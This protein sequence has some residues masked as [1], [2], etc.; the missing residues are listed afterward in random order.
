MAGGF[1]NDEILMI[2]IN[3]LLSHA[4][5]KDPTLKYRRKPSESL[6]STLNPIKIK[7]ED[8]LSALLAATGI[9][10]QQDAKIQFT[11]KKGKSRHVN[12]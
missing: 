1:F 12:V 7:T 8:P 6:N 3:K 9:P 10:Q 4:E 5:C 11:F 2:S